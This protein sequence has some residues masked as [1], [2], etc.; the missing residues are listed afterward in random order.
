MKKWMIVCFF[1]CITVPAFS[2]F[3]FFFG[4]RS[5]SLGYAS[6]A[7]NYDLNSIYLNPAILSLMNYSVTGYQ[8]QYGYRDYRN[9]AET[10]SGIFASDLR[11]FQSLPAQEKV[12]ILAKLNE[13]F[14]AKAGMQGFRYNNP[15]FA[16]HGYGFSLLIVDAALM[17]P[18]SSDI[19]QKSADAVTNA[20]IASLK[21]N[22]IGLHYK[23]YSFAVAFSLTQGINAGMTLHY[24]KGRISEFTSSLLDSPFG[25][26]VTPKEYLTYGWERAESDLNRFNVDLGLSADIGQYLKLGLAVRNALEPTINTSVREVKLERRYIA[27]IAF[28][29][30]ARWGVYL[31]ADL[32]KSDLYLNGNDAQPV[33]LGVEATLFKNKLSLRAGLLN[34][35]S[36]KYFFGSRANILYGMGM[37]LNLSNFLIDAALGVDRSGHIQNLGLSA[38]YLIQG[39]N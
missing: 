14:S 26:D 13:I 23:Q 36:E 37:G 21:M 16:G 12:D 25:K 30:S 7:F 9:G 27:G 35:L 19:L 15:G 32:K 18:V 29:P 31:D 24:L 10:L 20:D 1:L 33:S 11:N 6:V 5:L 38:F 4:A 39:K 22:F 8:Y 2:F 28:R 17:N 3:P 34:D